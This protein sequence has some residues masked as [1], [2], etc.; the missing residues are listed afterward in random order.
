MRFVKFIFLI[1][2][3]FISIT[4]FAQ[5]SKTVIAE[6]GKYKIYLDEFEKSYAKN[7]G[8]IE[9]AKKDSLSSLQKFLD[10][11]VNYRM[12]L[13]DA[14]IRGYKDD[15]SFKKELNDYKINVGTTLF[16]ENELYK[17]N[18]KMIYDRRKTEYR[19]SHIM[20]VPD[21]TMNQTQVIELS[22]QLIKRIK[23][24]EDFASLVKTYSKD[25]STKNNGGDVYYFTGG[26]INVPAIEDSLYKLE[27][28]QVTPEPVS[29][30]YAYHVIKITEKHPRIAS[31][32]ALHILASF[33]DTSNI[34]DSTK[35][36]RKIKEVQQK[37]KDGAD[38]SELAK[39]YSDDTGSKSNGGDLG[40]LAR[41]AMIRQFDEAAFKLKK[42]ETSDIIQTQFGYHLLKLIDIGPNPNFEESKDEVRETYKRIRFK[43]DY[44]KLCDKLRTEFKFEINQNTFSKIINKIKDTVKVNES[45]W[46][47][48]FQKELGGQS[49]LSIDGKNYPVDSLFTYMIK[50]DSYINKKLEVK[51]IADAIKDY[52]GELAVRTKALVYD[53][54][55]AEFAVLADDYEKG[56]YLFQ[57]LDEEVWTKLQV[58]SVKVESYWKA[59]K[60]NFKWKN[61]VE[62]KEIYNLSDTTINNCYAKTLA[63]INYDTLY[64]KYNQRG[65]SENKHGYSGLVEFDSNS[66]SKEANLLKNIGDIS[67]PFK[68][69][70]GWSIVKLLKRA[71][72]GVKT[73][74]E[75]KAEAASQ[76][77][78]IESKRLEEEYLNRLKNLYHPK[79]Y[80][81]ELEKA[82]K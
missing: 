39:Q 56:M 7:S 81:D 28:G 57:I 76:F 26:Q 19:A 74:D 27:E 29:S 46:K 34:I 71:P 77:Q 48:D 65:A 33:R 14:E 30:G 54:E 78:E 59:H 62:F 53:K 41:G 1:L 40:F 25:A 23:N 80:F 38:F 47:S 24:G 51:S 64:A 61:R 75:A 44:E 73:Y 63:G 55:N 17:P 10:L 15:E 18:M 50:T 5:S 37:L 58:D 49:V 45:Y 32:R 66:L 69:Q 13:R 82:F 60:D 42:G 2:P 31:V 6:F 16:L 70:D 67:K 68:N 22:K 72:A 12:K 20:L 21:S 3:L 4:C 79:I 43:Q 11:Y 35:A 8:G 9:K 52:S 36:L